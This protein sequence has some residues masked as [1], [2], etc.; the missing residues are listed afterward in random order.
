M[1]AVLRSATTRPPA[2]A[3]TFYPADPVRL[4]AEFQDLLAEAPSP[5]AI[6]PKALIVPH[7]G[8]AYSGPVAAAGF[9][10][11]SGV[12]GGIR[13]AVVIG[14]AHYV[15][16]S[17]IGAPT[18]AA[19]ATPLGDLPLDRDALA[20]L[21][22]LPFVGPTDAPHAPEHALEVEL[23]FLQACLGELAIVPLVI[24]EAGPEQV[25]VVLDRLWGGPERN[26]G[27]AARLMQ[28]GR[29]GR[30]AT[31]RGGLRRLGARVTKRRGRRFYS[32]AFRSGVR[33]P[34]ASRAWERSAMMSSICSIPTESRT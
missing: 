12:T 17:G 18:V 31:P 32:A 3:G 25:A 16:I 20:S 23:P 19:F 24:G 8:Y 2:V 14:P 22:D 7:A 34:A 26:S 5:P 33:R 9:A 4:R 10:A 11:L 1:G 27:A 29:H 6:R 13:R 21:A 15:P 28:L 30:T